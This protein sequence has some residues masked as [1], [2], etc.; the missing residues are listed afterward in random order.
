[1]DQARA[2]PIVRAQGA[3]A[4]RWHFGLLH[5]DLAL[6]NLIVGDDGQLWLIDF[7]TAGFYPRWFE[8]VNMV[9]DARI[10]R[11]EEYDA[12]WWAILHLLPIRIL[13]YVTG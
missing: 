8:Y 5:V 12:I 1:M 2:C 10:E 3:I 13:V 4:G 6:R 7:M 11:G 9:K